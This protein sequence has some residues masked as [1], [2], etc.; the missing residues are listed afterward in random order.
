MIIKFTESYT[1]KSSAAVDVRDY[2]INLAIS[3][4]SSVEI[5]YTD[6]EYDDYDLVRAVR[7][8]AAI[9]TVIAKDKEQAP[10]HYW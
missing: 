10:L 5:H 6:T 9:F 7:A 4:C 1:K 2:G 8:L 3:V